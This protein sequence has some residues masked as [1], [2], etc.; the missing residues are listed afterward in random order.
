MGKH[1]LLT[2]AGLLKWRYAWFANFIS[3]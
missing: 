3:M 2:E 1:K